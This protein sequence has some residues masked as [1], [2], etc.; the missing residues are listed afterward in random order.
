[1]W[2]KRLREEL[3]ASSAPDLIKLEGSLDPTRAVEMIAGRTR[4]SA[5]KRY[6]V[7]CQRWRLWLQE[8]K[9]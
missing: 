1:M 2:A 6:V 9:L 5:L 4:S 3:K 7:V 8:G